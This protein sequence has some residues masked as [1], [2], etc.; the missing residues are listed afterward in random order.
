[1]ESEITVLCSEQTAKLSRWKS[2]FCPLVWT[3]YFRIKIT[4]NRCFLHGHLRRL[5]RIIFLVPF[6]MSGPINCRVI[7]LHRICLQRF[8]LLSPLA[9]FSSILRFYIFNCVPI[10]EGADASDFCV[11]YFMSFKFTVWCNS[12]LLGV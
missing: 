12:Q 10:L 6:I 1:M 7:L 9:F 3:G 11:F 8:D 5:W 2:I 4:T